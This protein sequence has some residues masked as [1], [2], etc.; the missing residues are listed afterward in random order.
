MSQEVNLTEGEIL[1]HDVSL[2]VVE[3][4]WRAKWLILG[5][6][7]KAGNVGLG[8]CSDS[9]TPDLVRE[10]VSSL[11]GRLRGRTIAEIRSDGSMVAGFPG[12]LANAVD[13]ALSDLKAKVTGTA[14]DILPTERYRSRIPLYANINRAERDRT[15]AKLA[16][17]GARAVA[18]GFRAV[19]LAPFDDTN[20]EGGLAHL[21]ALREA[22]GTDVKL[23]VD[24]HHKLAIDEQLRILPQLEALNVVWLE[25]PATIDDIDGWKKVAA[26][27]KIP[28]AGGEQAKSL[29][30]V[31]LLL[32]SGVLSVVL[33]DARIAGVKGAYEILL[34]AQELG[35]R[36]SLHNH[37]GPVTTAASLHIAAAVPNFDI[38][39]YA[40]GEVPWRG[41]IL[42]PEEKIVGASLPVPNG[43]GLGVNLSDKARQL[44]CTE[45]QKSQVV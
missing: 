21:R 22:I 14:L 32:S 20:A 39:E 23:M 12:A 10:L 41:E 28:L 16:A 2:N 38:L 25:D 34:R 40:Y 9:G 4:T 5:L 35:I 43:P 11:A 45:S 6:V 1:I 42:T 37:L 19:K 17:L 7:D 24:A 31:E 8:E 15:S 36:S 3:A 26:A 30:D 44:L 18:D 29:E 13:L 33:P 27:T